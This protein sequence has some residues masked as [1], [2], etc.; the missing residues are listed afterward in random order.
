M[1][2]LIRNREIDM[3]VLKKERSEY[4]QDKPGEFQLNDMLLQLVEE[5][6]ENRDIKKIVTYRTTDGSTVTFEGVEDEKGSRKNI[7]C[8]NVMVRVIREV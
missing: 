6:P 2:E 7:R 4:I 8:S 1:V 5:H 3:A